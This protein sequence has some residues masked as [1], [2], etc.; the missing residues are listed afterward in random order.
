MFGERGWSHQSDVRTGDAA[1]TRSERR[2]SGA[3]TWI[4]DW[5]DDVIDCGDDDDDG[6]NDNYDGGNDHDDGGNDNDYGTDDN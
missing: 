1:Q 3:Q 4:Y 2:C 5:N 6:G